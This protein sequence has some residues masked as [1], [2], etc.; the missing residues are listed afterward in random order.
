MCVNI[1]VCVMSHRPEMETSLRGIQ[2]FFVVVKLLG[3]GPDDRMKWTSVLLLPL[4]HASDF[5]VH[6]AKPNSAQ[7]TISCIFYLF[8]VLKAKS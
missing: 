8:P 5:S 3:S 4:H 2:G 1:N 6:T 7:D